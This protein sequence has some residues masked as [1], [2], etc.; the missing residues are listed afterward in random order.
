M[1][2]RGV[3]PVD[4]RLNIRGDVNREGEAIRRRFLEVFG[5]A[6]VGASSG[7]GRLELA[8]HLA[9]SANPQTARV[10]VNRVWHWVFGAGIVATPSDFGKL[11]GRPSH[12]ELLDWLAIEF[13]KEGWS[14]K[15]LVRRLVLSRTFRQSGVVREKALD[16]DPDNRLL[17]HYPTRRLEAEAIRDSLLAVS[18]RLD[19]QLHGPPI[20]PPRY[21]EDPSKRLYSGPVDS[22][23]RRSIYMKMSIM[24]PPKFL[25]GFNFPD[26]KLPTGRRDVT[27]VPAQALALLNDPL[28][29]ELAEH[30]GKRVVVDDS[31]SPQERVRRMFVRATGRGPDTREINRWTTAVRGFSESSADDIM[32]QEQAW[33]ELAHV[34]F[35]MKE[36]IYYR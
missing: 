6:K 27:N 29:V 36:F 32:K 7:S 1:E 3:K 9:S 34:F 2:E 5:E 26:L 16:D 20:N 21:L 14:T 31:G 12:P 4:Y 28:V 18:G 11:G 35:N 19:P 17:H 33:S 15:K 23:G 22:H 25:V 30:W 8:D 13:V 10:Y 24:D